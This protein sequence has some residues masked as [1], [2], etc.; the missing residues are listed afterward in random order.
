MHTAIFWNPIQALLS[1]LSVLLL[2]QSLTCCHVLQYDLVDV[3][4][5]RDNLKCY[6][7]VF[8]TILPL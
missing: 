5:R 4:H 2:A 8:V 3:L 1:E 7:I 6:L